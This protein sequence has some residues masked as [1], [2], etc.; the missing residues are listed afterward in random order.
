VE[1]VPVGYQISA[2]QLSSVTQQARLYVS[3]PPCKTA[4]ADRRLSGLPA[5]AGP[6]PHPLR[7]CK[8]GYPLPSFTLLLLSSFVVNSGFL[9][10]DFA[11][12]LL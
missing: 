2:C 7:L 11:L 4:V 5:V 1:G 6:A 12:E 9:I 10:P 8:G 3:T